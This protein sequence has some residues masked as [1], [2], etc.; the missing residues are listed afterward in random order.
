MKIAITLTPTLFLQ[1]EGAA[2]PFV[3]LDAVLSLTV[4]PTPVSPERWWHLNF[5]F[6]VKLGGKI[7]VLGHNFG[8]WGP[9]VVY[10]S[11]VFTLAQA[12]QNSTFVGFTG[13]QIISAIPGATDTNVEAKLQSAYA[14]GPAPVSM[15]WQVQGGSPL[16]SS[17]SCPDN[18]CSLVSSVV[19]GDKVYFHPPARPGAYAV[20]VSSPGVRPV[21]RVVRVVNGTPAVPSAPKINFVGGLYAGFQVSWAPPADDHDS[22]IQSYTV[23]ATTTSSS[24]PS[25]RRSLSSTVSAGN[26]TSVVT[27]L[28][29]KAVYTV[30]VTASN[31]VGSSPRSTSVNVTALDTAHVVGAPVV[32]NLVKTTVAQPTSAGDVFLSSDKRWLFAMDSGSGAATGVPSFIPPGTAGTPTFGQFVLLRQ[33][34]ATRTWTVAAVLS[35]GK[36]AS[37]RRSLDSGSHDFWA[38]DSSGD[39]VAFIAG[40]STTSPK[41]LSLVMNDLTRP[42]AIIATTISGRFPSVPVS[43]MTSVGLSGDGTTVI[44]TA[45]DF[46]G[47]RSL[48]RWKRG[49]VAASRIDRCPVNVTCTAYALDRERPA[50]SRDGSVVAFSAT[51][52]HVGNTTTSGRCANQNDV[53]VWSASLAKPTKVS[54]DAYWLPMPPAVGLFCTGDGWWS[55]GRHLEITSD[56]KTV[57]THT[58]LV[59]RSPLMRLPSRMGVPSA[60]LLSTDWDSIA[61]LQVGKSPRRVSPYSYSVTDPISPMFEPFHA[62]ADGRV[63]VFEGQRQTISPGNPVLWA[64]DTATYRITALP[65]F[66]STS[67]PVMLWSR[68]AT[69]ISGDGNLVLWTDYSTPRARHSVFEQTLVH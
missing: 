58:S 50:V 57:I 42:G 13:I 3:E 8:Q 43:S 26:S 59:N 48:W 5:Q 24:V 63:V 65:M 68:Q 52:N 34:R 47:V 27:G 44:V 51:L 30:T 55:F 11:K 31:L 40:G 14:G 69:S 28:V 64:L 37:V 32:A 39:H 19:T 29:P 2:G 38:S 61:L 53:L 56:G 16:L 23:R 15:T 22:P 7:E 25:A 60:G 35:D 17:T 1:F 49:S 54:P 4:T 6:L 12:D 67:T 66:S 10:D 20:T 33:W 18:S 62:S 9:V 41:P 46:G 45:V 36:P 21:T